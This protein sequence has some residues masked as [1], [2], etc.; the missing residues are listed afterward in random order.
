MSLGWPG[1]MGLET[2]QYSIAQVPLDRF[3][4]RSTQLGVEEKVA[5]GVKKVEYSEVP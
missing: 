4:K 5:H 1:E 2:S 3:G